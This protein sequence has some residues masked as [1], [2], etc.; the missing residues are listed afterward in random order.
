MFI[1][2]LLW[3]LMM[4]MVDGRCSSDG[5]DWWCTGTNTNG[6]A[7]DAEKLTINLYNGKTID[8]KSLAKFTNLNYINL[9]YSGFRVLKS[10]DFMI[11]PKLAKLVISNSQ[12]IKLEKFELTGMYNC[13]LNH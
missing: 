3:I 7:S 1:C 10:R 9:G 5:T 11:F 2:V 12:K 4:G 8:L 13:F 6:V